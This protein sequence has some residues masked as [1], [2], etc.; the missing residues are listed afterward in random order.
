MHERNGAEGVRAIL[1]FGFLLAAIALGASA[2]WA[3][4]RIE[5]FNQ[6]R[7]EALPLV[8]SND[9]LDRIAGIQRLSKVPIAESVRLIEAGLADPLPNVRDAAYHSLVGMT[10][11]QEVCDTLLLLAKRA[12]KR[13][14]GSAAPL[15]AALLH[16]D[17]P[18]VERVTDELLDDAATNDAGTMAVIILADELGKH[19]K[20]ADVPPLVRLAKS[21]IFT[22]KFAARRAIV[23]A[24]ARIPDKQA[25]AALI[26][27]L[28]R[29]KGEA[30][31]DAVDYLSQVTGQIYGMEAGAWQRWWG[32][33][34]ENFEFPKLPPRIE[35]RSASL[36]SAGE[37]Y[38]LPLFAERLLF[39][40]D[41]SGSMTGPRIEAAKRELIR[42]IQGLPGHA[43]F[44]V[45]V[46]NGSVSAW[47]RKLVPAD[48]R[49]K[50]AA[51]AYIHSQAAHSNTASYDALEIALTFDTE[52]IYFVSDGNPNGG[53]I[54]APEQIIMAITTVN[55]ARRVS[56]YTIGVGVGF[57]GNPLDLFLK[58]LAEQNLGLYR[59]VDG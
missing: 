56:I 4:D 38:G 3:V 30:L 58:A 43:Q 8:R 10:G 28:H 19:G 52:A 35:Y 54:D 53:K 22:E 5:E 17:L 39:V 33:A 41:T 14:D 31:A 48:Q 42:A 12:G 34:G 15:L 36:E 32:E 7:K 23:Q 6:A 57:P 45:V 46:F 11:N 47:Q 40:L 21:R 29:V 1:R 37:Y 27:I 44:G 25:L 16:S 26:G 2:T 24:F 13:Q 50:R 9:P 51:I 55:Q 59:R 18:S 20:P 49:S